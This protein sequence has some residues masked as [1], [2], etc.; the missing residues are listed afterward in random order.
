[1]GKF[2]KGA[3]CSYD[4]Y[5]RRQWWFCSGKRKIVAQSKINGL[6]VT[7]AKLRHIIRFAN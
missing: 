7:C 2:K 5:I 4:T 6:V 1:M 3:K